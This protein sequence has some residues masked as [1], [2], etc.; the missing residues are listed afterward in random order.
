MQMEFNSATYYVCYYVNVSFC[1]YVK[2]DAACRVDVVMFV[3]MLMCL[4]MFF[5]LG[6]FQLLKSAP[7]CA[8]ILTRRIARKFIC[9]VMAR[10]HQF[11]RLQRVVCK[12]LISMR[13]LF[14]PFNFSTFQLL[15]H[16]CFGLRKL[17]FRVVKGKLSECE[18]RSFGR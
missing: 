16:I 18:R 13:L 8:G 1:L 11:M 12:T 7:L 2:N 14:Q 17:S 15:K 3:I 5:C 6:A 10:P 9:G 4:F